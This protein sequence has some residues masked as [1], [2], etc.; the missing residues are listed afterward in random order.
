ML[1]NAGDK[2][3]DLDHISAKHI[4]DTLLLFQVGCWKLLGLKTRVNYGL[5]FCNK[6]GETEG[7]NSAGIA[8]KDL[9]RI[10]I[11]KT[12]KVVG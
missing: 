5:K 8:Q 2:I 4:S 10:P 7:R 9:K 1:L 3:M 12:G 11:P 6:L